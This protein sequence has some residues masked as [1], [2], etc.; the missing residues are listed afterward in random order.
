M[1]DCCTFFHRQRLDK[2]QGKQNVLCQAEQKA[3]SLY[4]R[5]DISVKTSRDPE[6]DI[7]LVISLYSISYKQ[8]PKLPWRGIVQPPHS[9]RLY[10]IFPYTLAILPFSVT[11]LHTLPHQHD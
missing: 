3:L 9:S 7:V 1:K 6:A 4:T 10:I 11:F 5:H 2:W 8:L